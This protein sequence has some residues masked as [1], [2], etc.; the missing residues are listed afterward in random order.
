MF[1]RG[2]G[3]LADGVA[4]TSLPAP[5]RMNNLHSSHS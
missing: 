3:R 4:T 2:S 5:L 1:I